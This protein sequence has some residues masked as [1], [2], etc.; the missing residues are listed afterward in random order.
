M[1]NIEQKRTS[2]TYPMVL[3]DWNLHGEHY[4]AWNQNERLWIVRE[5]L[6]FNDAMGPEFEVVWAL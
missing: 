4:Q 6:P 2:P 3:A 1:T 5:K